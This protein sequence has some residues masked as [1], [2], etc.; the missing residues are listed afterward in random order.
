MTNFLNQYDQI[1]DDQPAQKVGFFLQA[2]RNAPFALSAELTTHRPILQTPSFVV[3][4]D[5]QDVVDALS[6][7]EVFNV[8]H[9]PNMDPSVGPFMLARDAANEN[10][11]EKSV[12][13]SLLRWEDLPRIRVLVA[14]KASALLKSCSGEVDLAATV[15]RQVPAHIVDQYFGVSGPDTTTLLAWSRATQMSFFYNLTRD[16]ALYQAGVEAGLALRA[17]IDQRIEAGFDDCNETVLARLARLSAA[18]H[19]MERSRVLSNAAGL[20]VGAVE[21][22]AHAIIHATRQLLSDPARCE[23]AHNAK[24]DPAKFDPLVWEALRFDPI[25]TFVLR[26]ASREATLA[27]GRPHAR[28]VSAG[29]LIALMTVSP[30]ASP[31][32]TPDPQTFSGDRPHDTYSHF[33]RGH[34]ECLGR[35]VGEQIIPETVRQIFLANVTPLGDCGGAIDYEGGPF[36]EHYRVRFG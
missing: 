27:P 36:P 3:V 19:A 35:Y 1:P 30:M 6:R 29:S 18:T 21:T 10:Y 26:V 16:P 22:N 31:G 2:A 24:D 11:Y 15:G 28:S 12:M 7:H 14:S 25:N 32:Y 33:G 20:L 4:A 5:A 23:A 17:W 13:R 34:H 9:A 8:P